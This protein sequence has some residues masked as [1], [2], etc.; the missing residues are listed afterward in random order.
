[1]GRL[2]P[3]ISWVGYWDMH[4]CSSWSIWQYWLVVRICWYSCT[5][6]FLLLN[7]RSYVF[8]EIKSSCIF[9][10]YNC[11]C[12]SG[13]LSQS[14]VIVCHSSEGIGMAFSGIFYICGVFSVCLY[15]FGVFCAFQMGMADMTV[16]CWAFILKKGYFVH[17]RP[18]LVNSGSFSV[19]KSMCTCS[20][21]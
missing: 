10:L 19:I 14:L 5:G 3:V 9:L 21:G 16:W 12:N 8:T 13:L 7:S 6:F 4:Y 18:W 20:L 1:M 17:C 15:W 11:C 2:W